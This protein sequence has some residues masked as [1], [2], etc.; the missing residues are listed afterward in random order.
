MRKLILLLILIVPF[1]S[2]PQSI[3]SFIEEYIDFTLDPTWFSINGVYTFVNHSGK[4]LD[5]PISFPF[6]ASIDSISDIR[7]FDLKHSMPLRIQKGLKEIAFQMQVGAFDTIS[8]NIAY[9]QK[10]C[11][12]NVYILSSTAAWREPLRKANY[13]L[14]IKKGIHISC[15][16][17]KP[18][19]E[20]N[21]NW[22]WKKE[23]FMP[24]H[25]FVIKL[26]K[27]QKQPGLCND[28]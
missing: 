24:N 5:A 15:F 20:K 2:R 4:T 8:I 21:Q 6:A 3:L 17:F 7:V 19:S 11:K 22:Y 16:S 14:T 26:G 23:R 18:D 27:G 13:T 1:K 28:E 25:E 10:T 9:K 12:R